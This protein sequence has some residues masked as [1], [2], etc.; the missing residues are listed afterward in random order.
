MKDHA[1]F[2]NKALELAKNAYEQGEV[3]VGA[4]IVKGEEILA[5][6]F[7]KREQEKN[8]LG[9]AELEAL[10][11]A[12]Q[13]LKNWRLG[14]CKL[15]VTLEP[16]LMCT[17]ALLESRMGELIYGASDPKKGCIHSLYELPKDSRFHHQMKITKGIKEKECSLLLKQF[18]RKIRNADESSSA[19]PC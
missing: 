2:M 9:H 10:F 7:N 16:C 8:P 1:F 17:G 4:L 12:S 18:F 6:G 13:K 19:F 14:D 5:E 11:K 15:Y 3:P